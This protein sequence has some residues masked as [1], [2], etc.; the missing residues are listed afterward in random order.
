MSL[1]VGKL[2]N[3]LCSNF[4]SSYSIDSI[5]L[6]HSWKVKNPIVSA[7][8]FH[9]KTSITVCRGEKIK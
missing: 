3:K 7:C 2:K 8:N 9:A 4:K 6:L 5:P 1:Q